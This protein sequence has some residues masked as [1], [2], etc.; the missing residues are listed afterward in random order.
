MQLEEKS[1]GW[2]IDH[3]CPQ[4]GA[5]IT[6][7]ETDR[8][9]SC[10]Y[11]RT[12]LYLIPKDYFRYYLPPSNLFSKDFIFIP[13]WRLRGMA[14]FCEAKE[15]GHKIIDV[16]SLALRGTLL[17]PSLGVRPQ[18]LKLR[19]VSPEMEGKSIKPHVPLD[20]VIRNIGV[21]LLPLNS[22]VSIGSI[23]HKAF[24]GETVSLI[25]SPIYVEK[26]IAYDAILGKS[27]ASVPKDFTD[28]LLSFNQQK[29]WP[30]QFVSTLCPNCGWDLLGERDSVALFCK[31]CN[32][33]WAASQSGL[34]ELNFGI[35]PSREDNTLYLPFWKMNIRIQGFKI[36]SYPDLIRLAEAAK[37]TK[38]EGKGLDLY[39]W[40][41]AF[42]VPPQLFLRL[43]Q[44]MTVSQPREEFERN[45]SG[46]SLYP[47]TL[48][49]HEATESIKITMANFAINK[50]KILPKLNEI[51]IKLNESLLIYLPFTPSGNDFIQPHTRLC[52]YKSYLTLGRDF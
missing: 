13:Y 42:K 10:S 46:S 47:V 31:N 12:R 27:L 4:C 7:E 11:C 48:P 36:Q 37:V 40:S 2:E 8:L 43:T 22:S 51:E 49:V 34:E 32:S 15:L 33:A 17:P 52:I 1:S 28:D 41:P 23:I 18:V 14:F 25:Y 16:S 3:Q 24:I 30:I 39:F 35:V 6:L 50:E 44:G 26:D 21:Q 5:S 19:F 20:T 38:E 45:L 29:D 9:F